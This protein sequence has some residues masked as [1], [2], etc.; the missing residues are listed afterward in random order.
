MFP[1]SA[2]QTQFRFAVRTGAVTLGWQVLCADSELFEERTD[3]F[4]HGNIGT[5]CGKLRFE[6]PP[7][8]V[9]SAACIKIARKETEQ[10]IYG[11]DG[12]KPG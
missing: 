11:S 6:V 5:L 1:C 12:A 9:F 8:H 10:H 4:Q 7:R 3:G 2:R